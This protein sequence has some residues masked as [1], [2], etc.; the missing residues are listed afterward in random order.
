MWRPFFGAVIVLSCA[1]SEVRP[2]TVDVDWPVYLGDNGRSHYS[3]LTQITRD[4]IADLRQVW[5]YDSGE[6]RGS[7]STMYTSP[8]VIDGVLYGLSPKLAAFALNAATGEELWN[9][10]PGLNGAA[11]RGLMWWQ[12]NDQA[13][14][15]YTAGSL[16]IGLDAANGT[17][18][19][20]F[21]DDGRVELTPDPDRGSMFVSVPGV[22][23]EDMIMLGFS[24]TEGA[25]AQKGSIRAFSVYTG[26]LVWQFDTI[27]A[28]GEPGSE[29]W[30]EGS[31]ENAG[32]A[33]VWT[34][35]ALDEARGILFA[36]TG[37][38]TPDFYGAGRLGDNLY[39]NSLLAIDVRSGELL[40]HYQVVRHDLWDRDNPAP[41]TLVQLQRDGELIDAVALTTK[42]GQLFLFE[43]ETGRS[44]YD[45]REVPTLPGN[46]SW[47][48]R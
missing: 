41:P 11:Q 37:S 14:L 24:T 42:S 34:G 40:W 3:P 33:N 29:T 6:L 23:F 46:S 9:Y 30:A 38:A 15:F 39:A 19:A 27:P 48:R 1:C 28:R 32:G 18:L 8:L 35:M 43:R 26:E 44:L 5:S 25:D 20:G 47:S 12:S 13:R 4:N 22:V 45:I 7:V 10:D 21:G 16:L 36:P 17:P 2:P 31:L